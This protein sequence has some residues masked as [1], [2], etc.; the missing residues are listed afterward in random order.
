MASQANLVAEAELRQ[1]CSELDSRLCAGESGVTEQILAA[2]PQLANS[3]ECAIE[4]IYTEY[5][6]REE[7][8]NRPQPA[9]LYDRFPQW[10]E[11]IERLLEVHAALESPAE[12]SAM[13]AGDTPG[14]ARSTLVPGQTVRLMPGD[15]PAD[16]A[17]YELIEPLG[18]GGMGIVYK[19]RQRGLDRLV[20]LKLIRNGSLA[21]AEQRSRFH[22]EAE[23]AARLQHPNI[24]QIF[25]IGE[26]DGTPFLAM[27]FVDGENLEQ[28]LGD[29]TL[30]S[31]SAAQLVATLAEAVHYAHERRIVH[32]DLKPAN[33]LLA[34]RDL[35]AVQSSRLDGSSSYEPKITDFGLAKR[36]DAAADLT[37]TGQILGTPNYMAPEQAAGH[38]QE[39][40]PATDVYAL[41]AI[42]YRLLTGR[43]PF[44]GESVLE[45]LEQLRD[46][47]P[48]AP[49][50]L[51]PKLPRDLQTICLKCLE[52]EPG[53][54]YAT[55]QALAMDLSR[56]LAG[57][58]IVARPAA[59]WERIARW[60]RRRPAVAALLA[61]VL[62]VAATGFVGVSWQWMRA[63]QHWLLAER[64]R[65]A[66]A[67]ALGKTETARKAEAAE[68]DRVKRLMY[69]HEIALA[70]HEQGN[71]NP[72]RAL[73]LLDGCDTEL[74]HWE[75]RYLKQLCQQEQFNLT[76][77]SLPVLGLA[78]SPDGSRLASCS[79][80]WGYD[81]PGEI[82]LWD[83]TNG[84]QLFTLRGHS[85]S[86]MS[87]AFSPDG[88]RLA[89]AGAVWFGK[90]SGV[91][92]WD[93]ATGTEALS[94]PSSSNVLSVAFSP[95]GQMLALGSQRG[96][97]LCDS[98]TGDEL[99]VLA[100][101]SSDVF[102]VAFN[103]NPDETQLAAA[104][105]DGTVR[106]WDA[107]SG[108][109]LAVLQGDNSPRSVCYSPDGRQLTV[110]T[111]GGTVFVWDVTKPIR[112]VARH[113]WDTR[114]GNSRVVFSPDGQH[115]AL[116][117]ADGAI[118]IVD[119]WTG[120][121]QQSFRAHGRGIAKVVAFSPDG[122]RIATAGGDRTIKLWD[123]L[124]S[125]VP[126]IIRIK[127]EGAHVSH[128]AISPDGQRV[129]LTSVLN[130]SSP[131]AGTSD[132]TL[133]IWDMREQQ[134][135]YFK[136]HSDWITSVAFS[137]DGRRFVTGSDDKTAKLCDAATGRVL[138]NLEGHDATVTDVA[139][140]PTGNQL[141][142]SSSDGTVRLWNVASGREL[143][144]LHAHAGAVSQVAYCPDGRY[145][146]SAGA[147]QMVRVWDVTTWR[148]LLGF[149]V[150]AS[151]I[152]D[153][154]FSPDGKQLALCGNDRLIRVW[155][156]QPLVRPDMVTRPRHTLRGHTDR[157]TSVAFS[158]DGKRLVS[159]S[160]DKSVKLWMLDSGQEVLTLRTDT[161][162]YSHVLFSPDSRRILL[163]RRGNI[164]MW[165]SD[166]DR[167]EA[168]QSAEQRATAW[169]E[170][171]AR[172]AEANHQCFG[173][174]FHLGRLIET[175]PDRWTYFY[176]RALAEAAMA[177]WNNAAADFAKVVEDV[178]DDL[179]ILCGQAPV[180]LLS[181]DTEGYHQLCQRVLARFQQTTEDPIGWKAAQQMLQSLFDQRRP[182]KEHRT[183]YL[184]ARLCTLAPDALADQEQ[185]VQ[186]AQQAVDAH[187]DYAWYLH[188]LALAHYRRGRYAQA[189]PL[190][191]ESMQHADWE[192]QVVNWLLLAMIHH[193]LG[194]P[195]DAQPW[196]DK[197]EQWL[198]KLRRE[199]PQEIVPTFWNPHDWLS[200]ELL[201][202]EAGSLIGAPP[203]LPA[204]PEP[205]R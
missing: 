152:H 62:V 93:V 205:D 17:R 181:G 76:G 146:I 16:V 187:P 85:S 167:E 203:T 176:R 137:P 20:A 1:A 33:V 100:G 2:Q 133:L 177:H 81:E 12:L 42:L 66:L 78:F 114:G 194:Q 83:A 90:G 105:R 162:E 110:A 111:F 79:A 84:K 47:D 155:D 64:G 186:I 127:K 53:N 3:P 69:A 71:H 163:S 131:G 130:R 36:L 198:E 184:A 196:L 41:G 103:P 158:P 25:D 22:K 126:Q 87:V 195:E 38:T 75:W 9:E 134:I 77:H 171:Q 32:R 156:V 23:S 201:R 116:S 4:L 178:P 102:C 138:L 72:E 27:E 182:A 46:H 161:T 37:S 179:E 136:E 48:V 165:D 45:V 104:S 120:R 49:S 117:T 13:R 132:R 107:S 24:V 61:M 51:R 202:Q 170:S 188:T 31:D 109:Q 89:S 5:V 54:R 144:K 40:G 119:P 154:A 97:K 168:A 185:A 174:A 193:Q 135:S 6:T 52:K 28:W 96:V 151:T 112:A 30:P 148:E 15:V 95:C 39:I 124:A 125:S 65:V 68:R 91:K 29:A 73:E 18:H 108:E 175:Q 173:A 63:H 14:D 106:L 80:K 129:A 140:S 160:P 139:F 58:S 74:R 115:L 88:A 122:R 44:Q 11:R 147:D 180:L 59:W 92:L 150:D 98:W 19:A 60:A 166:D 189:M 26:Q 190:L 7:L 164:V 157:V 128:M 141:A 159:V 200:C 57:Q 34:C 70:E 142:S 8:G 50:R 118:A 204:F 67:A 94:I 99:Q 86:V 143:R 197:A 145:L 101:G 121:E 199:A 43:A 56:F 123:L 10:R 21:T 192:P 82:I 113:Q 183:A 35:P 169:H 153:L 55:A 149:R 172:K 191:H